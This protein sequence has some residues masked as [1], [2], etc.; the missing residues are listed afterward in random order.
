[1]ENAS[2]CMRSGGHYD[3]LD[4]PLMIEVMQ[5]C[6]RGDKAYFSLPAL[7]T[8]CSSDSEF[9]DETRLCYLMVSSRCV[10]KITDLGSEVPYIPENDIQDTRNPFYRFYVLKAMTMGVTFLC[11]VT[12]C[13]LLDRFQTYIFLVT[14]SLTSE[15]SG[16][17]MQAALY[18]YQ[19]T[20]RRSPCFISRVSNRTNYSQQQQNKYVLI[21]YQAGCTTQPTSWAL[22]L[23]YRV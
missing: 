15:S 19:T 2:V 7:A 18:M 1:M 5:T 20:R 22:S 6:I 17:K 8:V 13:S 21:S 16:L 9:E 4:F 23:R 12:P 3:G 10:K 14:Q 11:I